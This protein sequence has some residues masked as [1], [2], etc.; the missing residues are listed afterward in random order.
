MS[1]GCQVT[2][3]RQTFVR[4]RTDHSVCQT[5]TRKLMDVVPGR[6][7]VETKKQLS[8]E[9]LYTTHL[10]RDM[11]GD[12]SSCKRRSNWSFQVVSLWSTT[13]AEL[14]RRTLDACP[15][16]SGRRQRPPRSYLRPQNPRTLRW[17]GSIWHTLDPARLRL[18]SWSVTDPI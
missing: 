8:Y 5:Q 4:G 9:L 3:C 1:S 12:A 17:G 2:D 10:K 14:G 11:M 6:S 15:K 7:P 13:N 18:V 16:P